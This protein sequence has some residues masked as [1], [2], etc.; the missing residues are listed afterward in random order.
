MLAMGFEGTTVFSLTSTDPPIG[1]LSAATTADEAA[2]LVTLKAAGLHGEREVKIDREPFAAF[3]RSL[4]QDWR[5][6]DRERH[7]DVRQALALDASNDGRGHVTMRI[8]LAHP[9][10]DPDAEPYDTHVGVPATDAGAWSA[11]VRV[12]V[13]VP[14][15]DVLAAEAEGLPYDCYRGPI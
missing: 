4:A 13:E 9:W 8:Q 5:G 15:L 11:R 6:W 14:T 12:I 10:L 2:H 7:L 1:G 3:F